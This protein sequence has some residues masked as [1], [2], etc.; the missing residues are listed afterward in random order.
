MYML[1]GYDETSGQWSD[2]NVNQGPAHNNMFETYEEAEEMRETLAEQFECPEIHIRV[3]EIPEW[4]KCNCQHC[5]AER[6]E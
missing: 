5:R 2:S 6:G 3:I 1:E 4:W